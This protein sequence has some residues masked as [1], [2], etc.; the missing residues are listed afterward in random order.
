[1]KSPANHSE[2]GLKSAEALDTWLGLHCCIKGV[3]HVFRKHLRAIRQSMTR[4][5]IP[6]PLFP[7]VLGFFSAFSVITWFS[8]LYMHYAW[9]RYYNFCKMLHTDL[10]SMFSISQSLKNK[11]EQIANRYSKSSLLLLFTRLTSINIQTPH[12]HFL[13]IMFCATEGLVRD[14]E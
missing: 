10:F 7:F 2:I 8:S 9:S 12:W 11:T 1:M 6:P 13:D 14:D 4:H 5:K 3:K